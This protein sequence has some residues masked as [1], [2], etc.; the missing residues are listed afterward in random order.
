MNLKPH[1][2]AILGAV[3]IGALSTVVPVVSRLFLPVLWLN[4]HFHELCHAIVAM[5]CGADV[6]SIHVFANGS[7]VTPVAGGNIFLEA[8]AGYVGSSIIGA[9]T[10]F[11]SRNQQSARIT[12]RALSI[13]LGL[14]MILLVRGDFVGIVSGILWTVC[15]WGL[16]YLT[17]TKLIFAAQLLGVFQCMNAVQSMYTLLQISAFTEGHSDAMI[18]QQTTGIPAIVWAIGW[19]V[20]S[21]FVMGLT[22]LRAW[23]RPVTVGR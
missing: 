9:L 2:S 14:S 13:A 1:Q 3:G 16:S 11:F 23:V 17:G 5:A 19:T 15:L 6:Q 21:L 7:G 12:L 20:F 22:L 8:S 18:L 10:I 4:T